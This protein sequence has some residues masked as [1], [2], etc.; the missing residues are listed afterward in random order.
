MIDI[1]QGVYHS[2]DNSVVVKASNNT[3]VVFILI[4]T[5][6]GKEFEMNL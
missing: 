1:L 2:T 6:T 4:D 5:Y 3:H